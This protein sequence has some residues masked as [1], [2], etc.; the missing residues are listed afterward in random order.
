MT[1]NMPSAISRSIYTL[2]SHKNR[3]NRQ[4]VEKNEFLSVFIDI[5]WANVHQIGEYGIQ[6]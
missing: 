1:L 6:S 2:N 4:D 5:F 3:M